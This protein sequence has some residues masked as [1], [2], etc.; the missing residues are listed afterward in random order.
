VTNRLMTSPEVGRRKPTCLP[1]V[2]DDD[3][4]IAVTCSTWRRAVVRCRLTA[5]VAG[6]SLVDS[7]YSEHRKKIRRTASENVIYSVN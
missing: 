2:H 6:P 7:T 5:S 3:D 4:V 1:E